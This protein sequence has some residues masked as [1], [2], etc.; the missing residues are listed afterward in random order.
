MTV[1][2]NITRF[3]GRTEEGQV[4]VELF[5]EGSEEAAYTATVSED[6]ATYT[7]TGVASGTYTMKVSKKDH[8]TRS[9]D[10]TVANEAVA[11]DV[12]IHL[13]GDVNGDGS[14]DTYD[15]ARANSHARLVSFLEGYELACADIDGDGEIT[16]FD[17]AR[18]NS[19]A[20][21]VSFLW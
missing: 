3:V 8:V 7:F 14:V 2:G 6:N 10:V 5:A 1:S 13:L 4:F 18:M 11:Q 21:L 17:V 12:K 9:Y 16:T 15:V 19:H 20:R